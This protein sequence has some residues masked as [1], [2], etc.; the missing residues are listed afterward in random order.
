MESIGNSHPK[1]TLKRFFDFFATDPKQQYDLLIRQRSNYRSHK[2]ASK[3]W[4][5]WE[6][7]KPV[8]LQKSDQELH[9]Y[10]SRIDQLK[11]LR[12]YEEG[13]IVL[14][15]KLKEQQASFRINKKRFLIQ[16]LRIKNFGYT[17]DDKEFPKYWLSDILKA[18][19][20]VLKDKLFDITRLEFH[21]TQEENIFVDQLLQV[22]VESV[23]IEKIYENFI[24]GGLEIHEK[25]VIDHEKNR[26]VLIHK[27]ELPGHETNATNL[28]ISSKIK[29]EIK[30]LF[31]KKKAGSGNIISDSYDEKIKKNK[32]LLNDYFANG[33]PKDTLLLM[34]WISMQTEGLEMYKNSITDIYYPQEEID[35]HKTT[36]W[37]E[38]NEIEL[39][40][41]IFAVAALCSYAAKFIMVDRYENH[42]RLITK[43]MILQVF[44][45]FDEFRDLN[46]NKR[47][48]EHI[49]KL[50]AS[51]IHK[52]PYSPLIEFDAH[53]YLFVPL[54]LFESKGYSRIL[55][56]HLITDLIFN[57]AINKTKAG[58]QGEDKKREIAVCECIKN[59]IKSIWPDVTVLTNF[60]WPGKDEFWGR[61]GEVD[62]VLYFPKE[63]ILN[64]IE[65][66]LSNT[67]S[68]DAMS[69]LNWLN[70]KIYAGS[71]S[72]ATQ[73]QK[74]VNFFRH[75]KALPFIRR[76][77]GSSDSETFNPTI[78]PY[79]FT[80]VFWIDNT[81]VVFNKL[82]DEKAF[83]ISV[84]QF[85]QMLDGNTNVLSQT[86]ETL[87]Q[88]GQG[89]WLNDE[90]RSKNFWKGIENHQIKVKERFVLWSEGLPGRLSLDIR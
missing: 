7:H 6:E 3:F 77:L 32:M 17:F 78:V 41:I 15:S 20:Y 74:D 68:K 54:A 71:A 75:S 62:L 83:C 12:D 66:K 87:P 53:N 4:K 13:L 89:K 11:L 28:H 14:R 36:F 31:Y 42:A 29:Q 85:N 16:A 46:L 1:F 40:H 49:I 73:L 70:E 21:F 67:L 58:V 88:S 76:S 82:T 23:F 72:A 57:R 43:D 45:E 47:Q 8:F 35:I 33:S 5:S 44:S 59:K 26:N 51:L 18:Y 63:N 10:V 81:E 60:T 27:I 19:K 61:N 90:I 24:L 55:Y 79:I 65:L 86:R 64:L 9:Y 34:N 84:F 52:T 38:E 48:Q 30:E 56:D 50:L 22:Y 2:V 80:D 25:S 39:Q 69:K 37:Y